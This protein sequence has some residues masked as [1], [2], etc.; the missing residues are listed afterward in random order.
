M[1]FIQRKRVTL[2]A[3]TPKNITLLSSGIVA[4]LASQTTVFA[5]E[6]EQKTGW[7]DVY[8]DHSDLDD[9]ISKAES[10]GINLV[11]K[12]SAVLTGDAANTETN[13]Q[14]AKKYYETKAKELK[15]LASQ[16]K[17][18]MA[19]YESA[20]K[21]NQE[22][23]D[24]ANGQM[25]ALRTN[26]AVNSQ[27]VIHKSKEYSAE[28]V[29]QDA[30]AIQQSIAVG[31]KYKDINAEISNATTK[32]ASFT[33]FQTQASQGNIVVNRQTVKISN[34]G[35]TAQYIK[36]VE[37]EAKRLEDY[38]ANSATQANGQGT[39]PTFTLYDFVIDEAVTTA[40]S[41]PVTVYHY[42][43][44]AVARPATPTAEYQFYDIR[45]TPNS[46][47][48]VENADG[49]TIIEAT[50]AS[51]NGRKV[52]QAV[53]NQIV[54]IE[55]DNEPLPSGR[56][57][58]FHSIVVNTYLPEN[59]EFD[60]VKSN[61][62]S[63][64]WESTYNKN[65][66]IITSRATSKYLVEVNNAQNK[67]KAGTVGG[68]V[69][70]QFAYHSPA[71]YF[72][73][74]KDNTTYQVHSE[75]IVNDEYLVVGKTVTIKTEGAN[76][77]KNNFNSQMV[78]INGRA[79]LPGSINNFVIGVD[80]DQYKGVNIDRAMQEK[81]TSVI[82]Y[83]PAKALDVTGPITIKD[84]ETGKVLYKAEVKPGA[85]SGNFVN[86]DGKTVDGL[87]W[88]IIDK[89]SAPEQ[90]KLQMEDDGKALRVDYKKFDNEF[91]KTYVE[92]GRNVDVVI[93]MITKKID[94]TPDK[95]GGTYN[96]NKYSNVAW[97]SDF[98]NEYKTNTVENTVPLLDPRKD[99]VLSFANLTSQDINANPTSEIEKGSEFLYRFS[100]SEFPKNLADSIKSYVFTEEM[101]TK[102]DEYTGQYIVEANNPIQFKQGTALYRRY[103]GTNGVMPANTDI[104]KFTTQTIARNVSKTL[105]TATG[106]VNNADTTVT[107]VMLTFD[108][109]FLDQIDWTNTA[110]HVDAFLKTK[111]IAD[112]DN[113]VNV[114]NEV[115]N[116]IDFGST[117]TVTNTKANQLDELK[118]SLSSLDSRQS[119]TDKTVSNLKVVQDKQSQ[120]ITK[121]SERQDKHEADVTKFKNETISALS[122][123]VKN[124]K[125][126]REAIDANK[127]DA[128]KKIE[129][130][131]TNINKNATAIVNLA[132]ELGLLLK[133][134]NS[135][136]K[137]VET[138]KTQEPVK[139]DNVSNRPLS[140]LVV[141]GAKTDA[142]ALRYAVNSGVASSDIKL[143]KKN[144]KGQYEVSYVDRDE[145]LKTTP[146]VEA[147]K[148][149]AKQAETVKPK[150]DVKLSTMV[151]YTVQSQE[152]AYAQL[153]KFGYGK[154]KVKSLV[155]N[156]KGQWTAQVQD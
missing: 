114:F 138:P 15:D 64:K 152:A 135:T 134:V 27:S 115:I 63:D 3:L 92:G 154:D 56:F 4:V 112:V 95:Q 12:D 6:A 120:D 82:D 70:G 49:E 88:S 113:V 1:N 98:G 74:L 144:D 48:H 101:N 42:T 53:K 10:A 83:Y 108:Q 111:R 8:V 99:A 143:I 72:K 55:T 146:K 75:T 84:R 110:F 156:D 38:L 58:K 28:A 67:N 129:A 16:Y 19:N 118:K 51:E 137:P 125:A 119:S 43:P 126:N 59:V 85:T 11:H 117:E 155:R 7:I 30:A 14:T 57:D 18:D 66:R 65:T 61:L 40:A 54:G 128:D 46:N 136:E 69:N 142:E 13:I 122:V 29:S 76:P 37:A 89:N 79:L 91:Y 34:V 147:P 127:A 52:V 139:V 21:R 23:A 107:R 71:A 77:T 150:E 93:P 5:E 33:S 102:A 9:A 130:N 106:T 132:K 47:R 39:K 80:Y 131:A 124:L 20:V 73:L 96:G 145:V 109:D 50:K 90:I 60:E 81:G 153:E 25:D 2:N 35:D 68:T 104:T 148:A 26:L 36:N 105:N 78:N 100:G 86:A 97:Q 94:N 103:A 62:D 44:K 151:L 133:K 121:L 116:G 32:Q 22:D 45:S 31:K 123:V 87:T 41:A 140:N 141:Y 149:P 17:T 24:N